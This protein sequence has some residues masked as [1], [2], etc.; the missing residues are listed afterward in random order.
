MSAGTRS[1]RRSQ[2]PMVFS[3]PSALE[4][5]VSRIFHAPPEKVFRV[6]TDPAT[7]PYVFSP[8]PQSVTVE[9]YEFRKGGRY[10]I[11]VKQEDGSSIRYQ[12]EYREIEPPRR[13]VNTFEVDG[14]PARWAVETD[15]FEPVGPST[16]VTIRW[17]FLSPEEREKM[18]GPAG[19]QAITRM[20]DAVAG[21]LEQ[22]ST[23]LAEA[24]A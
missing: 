24:R 19:E 9:R 13:V 7:V 2:E 20:W 16:R 21:L 1:P 4:N 6:F 3:Q 23:G 5:Q 8:D 14:V 11:A 22:T 18:G 17:K 12:G 15:E 10:S